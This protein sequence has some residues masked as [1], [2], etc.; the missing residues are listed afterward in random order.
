MSKVRH[1]LT[2]FLSMWQLTNSS[3]GYGIA[4]PKGSRWRDRIS[5]AILYLQEKSAIQ[6]PAK[7]VVKSEYL[8]EYNELNG[9]KNGLYSTQM[10]YNQW[11]DK[12]GKD[13]TKVKQQFF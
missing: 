13:K 4:T 11:W 9:L 10:L 8:E 1:D 6:V 7:D 3:Q 5:Q 2:E 12:N